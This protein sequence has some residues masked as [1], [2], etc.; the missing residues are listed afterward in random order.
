MGKHSLNAFLH[1]TLY[2]TYYEGNHGGVVWFARL[3][4]HAIDAV[5]VLL[6]AMVYYKRY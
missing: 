3:G 1:R 5:K 4:S 2:N 6:M